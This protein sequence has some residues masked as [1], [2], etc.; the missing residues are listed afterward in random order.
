MDYKGICLSRGPCID[1]TVLFRWRFPRFWDTNGCCYNYCH[2]AICVKALIAIL[3]DAFPISGYH[4]RYYILGV[5]FLG[6]AGLCFL[7]LFP[8]DSFS[9][10]LA[11]LCYFLAVL[12]TAVIDILSEGAY[13]AEMRLHPEMAPDLMSFVWIGNYVT[14]TVGSLIAGP[15]I[16]HLSKDT[17]GIIGVQWVLFSAIPF[18]ASSIFAAYFNLLGEGQATKVEQREKRQKLWH[19][20]EIVFLSI[21]LG[22]FG[23]VY[24]VLGMIMSEMGVRCLSPSF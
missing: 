10:T 11:I 8:G 23:I 15:M 17:G 13:A 22:T 7:A 12:H 2:Y 14:I 19:Q 18:A 5:S 1:A 3:S 20:K 9:L 16:D 4:K 6:T 24:S 21:M